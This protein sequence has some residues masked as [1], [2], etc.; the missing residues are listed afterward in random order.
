[1][2]TV[3]YYDKIRQVFRTLVTYNLIKYGQKNH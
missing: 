3:K 2:L 1:M